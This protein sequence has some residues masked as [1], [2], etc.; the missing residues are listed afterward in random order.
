MTIIILFILIS[1][2]L[3]GYMPSW[4]SLENPKSFLATEIYSS[5]QE[6]I[7]TYFKENRS[8]VSY[9]KLS[10]YLVNA[11][12]ATEDERFYGHSGVDFKSL[13]RVLY[14]RGKKGGGSTITQQLAKLFYHDP[15]S[16]ILERASQKL[17]EWVIAVKLEK[18]YTKEEIISMYFNK[19]DF[20]NLA[21]GIKSA[22]KVY[23]NTSPDSLKIEQAAMLVGMAKN[24]ALYNPLRRY[25]LT[26]GR[27]NIVLSQ[28]NKAGY[29]NQEK[30]DSLINLP[31]ELNYQKVDHKEGIATYFREF[32]RMTM[33]A[34]EPDS[35]KY[36]DKKKFQEDLDQWRNNPLYGWCNKNKKPDGTN[37]DIY[38]DGLKIYTTINSKMQEYAE[39]AV[40]QHLTELQKIFDDEHRNRYD[41]QNAPFY[42][43]N[44]EKIEKMMYYSMKRSER[45]RVLKSYE[46]NEDS[47]LII[48]DT[49]VP[50]KIFS[51]DGEID[52]ILT[53][54]DS[55]R[56]YK[57]Y[58]RAGFMSMEPQTGYVRA[59]VGGANYK[60]F[61]FDQVTQ[62]RRQVGSTFKPFVY[63][64]AMQE[65]FSPCYKVPNILT[66]FEMPDGQPPWT[67]RDNS[68]E[69]LKG[70]M[71][72][73]KTGLSRS[74]NPI[75]AWVIKQFSPQAVIK[76]AGAMG[77]KSEIPAVPSI[78]LGV[79][80]VKLSEMVGA[81]TTFIDKGIYTE[82]LYV[83]RIED[84]DGNILSSFI[85]N[86]SEAISE[87]TAYL[88]LNMLLAVTE[89]GGT[90]VRL[91]FKYGMTG[92]I[93]GKTGT[94]QN[95][96]DG[97]FMGGTPT[98]LSGAWVGCE[99]RAAHFRGIFYGQGASL[100]LPIWAY[101]MKKVY[102]DSTLNYSPSDKFEK[103]SKKIEIET[104]CAKYDKEHQNEFEDFDVL[105][106][107]VE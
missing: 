8:N 40:V 102:A 85:A 46:I 77:I 49:P 19:F 30:Y 92:P 73:L 29:I 84:K 12:I 61:Q 99:D 91:R 79:A 88:M 14:F 89:G 58:L 94:T 100:A 107:A 82:P 47:I 74:L 28:M 97:W 72:S 103:P 106:E 66:T 48:F 32:L 101:Y 41:K 80:D 50:M 4:D 27:R 95:H 43:L 83:T 75:A 60:H 55:M 23:F 56:Y 3:L 67:P 62:S 2:G 90:G 24:P 6:L 18:R 13:V 37:Y 65:G 53:P 81:Y 15:A 76:V 5:D 104:D 17:N 52:T 9:E 1:N 36:A 39:E 70:K 78:C 105:N 44:A 45:Y 51:W 57:F 22:A 98:L 35:A 31:I 16:N 93:A 64:L 38:R 71:I 87:E 63:T 96:S 7:G 20:L 86:K 69:K 59:Y 11:L 34:H 54:M 42:G 10:P 26:L 21:V 68:D 33:T 25:D